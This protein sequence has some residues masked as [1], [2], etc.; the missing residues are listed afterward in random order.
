MRGSGTGRTGRKY[1]RPAF[2]QTLPLLIRVPGSSSLGVMA[3][4]LTTTTYKS[5]TVPLGR[6]SLEETRIRERKPSSSYCSLF[7]RFT[8]GSSR[9]ERQHYE[10]RRDPR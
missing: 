9:H 3:R 7:D 5:L 10:V 6:L 2:D 1:P 4:K 8:L